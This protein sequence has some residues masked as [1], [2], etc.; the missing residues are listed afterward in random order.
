MDYFLGPN[1]FQIQANVK[2]SLGGMTWFEFSVW[3]AETFIY[4]SC[5]KIF[6]KIDMQTYKLTYICK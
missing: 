5:T 3:K 2:L 6:K 4:G 1:M